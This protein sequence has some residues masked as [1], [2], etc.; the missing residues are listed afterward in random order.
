MNRHSPQVITI[1]CGECGASWA[2]ADRAHCVG[3]RFGGCCRTFDNATIF[4]AHR[5][6]DRCVHPRE[7]GLS[8]TKNHI[9]YARES[10]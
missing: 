8:E 7:L 1:T 4:D 5:V 2:G 6:A 10:A 3:G 9:F